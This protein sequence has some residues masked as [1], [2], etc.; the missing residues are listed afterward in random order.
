MKKLIFLIYLLFILNGLVNG[1]C[2]CL[3]ECS[4]PQQG[5]C[6]E[7]KY[8]ENGLNG[9]TGLS[10]GWNAVNQIVPLKNKLL[11][12]MKQDNVIL[13]CVDFMIIVPLV[14]VKVDLLQL[15]SVKFHFLLM[16]VII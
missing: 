15:V 6:P 1:S 5:S 13:I 4:Q 7:I 2:N 16:D 9:T 10:R 3:D 11:K 14:N 8:V 12:E